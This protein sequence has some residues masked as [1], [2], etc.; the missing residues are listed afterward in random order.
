LG[1]EAVPIR[2]AID[3]FRA[4][5]VTT[6]A[7]ARPSS[8]AGAALPPSYPKL[9]AQLLKSDD[10]GWKV[11]HNPAL[12][13]IVSYARRYG[14]QGLLEKAASEP[15]ISET[16][17]RIDAVPAFLRMPWFLEDEEGTPGGTPGEAKE[18]E[19]ASSETK[20]PKGTSSEAG[21]R[22]GGESKRLGGIRG[23]VTPRQPLRASS[24]GGGGLGS[25]GGGG[26]KGLGIRGTVTAK[27]LPRGG[28]GGLSGG[29]DDND[30]SSSTRTQQWFDEAK[31]A[32][33]G[34]EKRAEV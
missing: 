24:S 34:E 16:F 7:A 25:S 33:P 18:P 23:T 27:R 32:A 8:R 17:A 13:Q 29:G 15:V 3:L 28:N 14:A 1:G 20:E 10:N 9:L 12:G 5:F 30:E 11:L 6:P 26:S 22:S 2:K 31:E 4:G 21:S 19:G